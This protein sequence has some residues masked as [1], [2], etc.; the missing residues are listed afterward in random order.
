[1]LVQWALLGTWPKFRNASV[2]FLR[3][4]LS[5]SATKKYFALETDFPDTSP[6]WNPKYAAHFLDRTA[7]G[8]YSLESDSWSSGLATEEFNSQEANFRMMHPLE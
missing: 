5:W 6:P 8:W 7:L 3:Q 4:I 2:F 1:M